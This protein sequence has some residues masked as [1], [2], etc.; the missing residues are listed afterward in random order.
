MLAAFR[1]VLVGQACHTGDLPSKAMLTTPLT[2][3]ITTLTHPSEL[4]PPCSVLVF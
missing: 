4:C 3:A 1:A 2:I